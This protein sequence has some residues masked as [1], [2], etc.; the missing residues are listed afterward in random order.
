MHPNLIGTVNPASDAAMDAGA[1]CKL[2][3]APQ[4]QLWV[5]AQPMPKLTIIERGDYILL[6]SCPEC[7][8]LWCISPYEPYMSAEYIVRWYLSAEDWR[9]LH[10]RDS[11]HTLRDWHI[12][13]CQALHET[14]SPD[15]K[16]GVESH[17]KRTYYSQNPIDMKVSAIP[18]LKALLTQPH[19]PLL[20]FFQALWK[21]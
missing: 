20:A 16:A 5:P 6:Q 12:A 19:H 10:D 15:E 2:C 7:R 14:L 17:R 18:N 9:T 11:G 8:R 3:E 1:R 13:A 21:R 4:R